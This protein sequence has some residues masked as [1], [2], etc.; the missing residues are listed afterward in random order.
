MDEY[1][2]AIIQLYQRVDPDLT[3]PMEDRIRQFI[4]GLRNEIREQVEIACPITMEEAINKA[5][6]VEATYSKNSSLSTYSLHCIT[7]RN[8]KLVDI[9]AILTQLTQ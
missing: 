9:K 1:E 4:I 2:D 5:R 3:Y 7:A 8:R 6:V